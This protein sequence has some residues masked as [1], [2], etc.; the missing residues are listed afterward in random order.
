MPSSRAVRGACLLALVEVVAGLSVTPQ[1]GSVLRWDGGVSPTD[2]A[3]SMAVVPEVIPSKYP[4]DQVVASTE[5]PTSDFIPTDPTS[6]RSIQAG[7]GDSWCVATC[8]KACPPSLCKCAGAST[9]VDR[10]QKEAVVAPPP[11]IAGAKGIEVNPMAADPS[12]PTNL[13]PGS[14]EYLCKVHG[15]CNMKTGADPT[16][17]DRS[18]GPVSPKLEDAK[19][20]HEATEEAGLP[21]PENMNPASEEFMCKIHGQ[22]NAPNATAIK[23]LP[24]ATTI[25]AQCR[26]N[27]NCRCKI[28]GV[29]QGSLTTEPNDKYPLHHAA[30]YCKYYALC[31]NDLPEH[32]RGPEWRS[33]SAILPPPTQPQAPKAALKPAEPSKEVQPETSPAVVPAKAP[34]P[35]APASSAIAPSEAPAPSAIGEMPVDP[36]V[37]PAAPIAPVVVPAAGQPLPAVVPVARPLGTPMGGAQAEHFGE[38]VTLAPTLTLPL[39]LALALA[40]AQAVALSLTL[41]L[42]R[43]PNPNPNQ[44]GVPISVVPPAPTLPEAPVAAAVQPAGV[45]SDIPGA[46]PIAPLASESS[47]AELPFRPDDASTCVSLSPSTTDDWCQNTCAKSCPPQICTCEGERKPVQTTNPDGTPYIGSAGAEAVP[48]A[49]S[50][51]PLTIPAATPQLVAKDPSSCITVSTSVTD[52]WCVQS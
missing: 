33:S 7:V 41:T 15:K 48:P 50:P 35:E 5:A 8:T 13:D 40:L 23:P 47:S 22:C 6:C 37:I 26:A 30:H 46:N 34:P 32:L 49:V 25:A 2:A 38:Q 52:Q 19:S 36:V 20:F 9:A 16:S 17:A 27:A 14:P 10:I 43:N 31:A 44:G 51:L 11:K 24:N 28:F 3:P 12:K 29:C 21:N 45:G 4:V 1:E 42:A 18:E 39:T